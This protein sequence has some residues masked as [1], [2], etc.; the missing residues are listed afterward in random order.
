MLDISQSMKKFAGLVGTHFEL[1]RVFKMLELTAT[2][3]EK[4]FAFGGDSVR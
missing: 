2:T 1:F 3:V 4:V